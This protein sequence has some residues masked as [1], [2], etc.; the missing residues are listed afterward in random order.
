MTLVK[1]MY[2]FNDQDPLDVLN[3]H[4]SIEWLPD[5]HE[6]A[7]KRAVELEVF[8]DDDQEKLEPYAIYKVTVTIEKL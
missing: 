3:D 4:D 2:V 5:S 6:E 1:F 7:V 8:A